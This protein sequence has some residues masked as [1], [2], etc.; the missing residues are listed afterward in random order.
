MNNLKNNLMI[1]KSQSNLADTYLKFQLNE[2]TYAALPVKYLHEVVVVPFESIPSIPNMP[3]CILGLINWRSRIIWVIDL[4]NMLNLETV[5]G[6]SRQ[7]NILVIQIEST[8]L[9]LVVPEIIGTTRLM[10]NDIESPQEKF[11]S[12]LL[13]YLRGWVLQNQEQ[14]LVLNTQAILQSAIFHN[15]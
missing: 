2:F 3:A 8:A 1:N 6:K 4:P 14:L 5:S 9:A 11:S 15:N 7:H 10:P 12:D 13:P